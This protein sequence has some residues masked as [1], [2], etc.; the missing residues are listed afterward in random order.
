[1]SNAQ[2]SLNPNDLLA[3]NECMIIYR[4][5]E[6]PSLALLGVEMQRKNSKVA[7]LAKSPSSRKQKIYDGEIVEED[8]RQSE[9]ETEDYYW[10]D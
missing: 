3:L 7:H 8:V 5:F 4:L 6:Q 10:S 9:S 1:M 2:E